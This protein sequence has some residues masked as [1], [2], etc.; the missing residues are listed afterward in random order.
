MELPAFLTQLA[1]NGVAVV[2]H[3]EEVS[4]SAEAIVREW[5][6]VQRRELAG[7]APDLNVPAAEW[8]AVR[9]YRGCQAL[10]CREMPPAEMQTMLRAPCP[11][12]ASIAVDYSVDLVFRFLH[13]LV[14]LARRVSRNDPLVDE[15]LALGRDW[16]LSSV[17]IE[18][19]GP[20]DPTRLHAHPGLWQLYIDRVFATTDVTRLQ[21]DHVRASVN[22]ALGAFPELAPAFASA[23]SSSPS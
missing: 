9:L 3:D 14:T 4:G 15:L 12:P 19:L 10:V 7:I 22:A 13:D 6:A 11:E 5:D 1:E 18:D 21:D 16:P 2:T 20:V 8:A 23:L 17:G